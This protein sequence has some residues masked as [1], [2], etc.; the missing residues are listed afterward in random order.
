MVAKQ[1]SRHP[2]V[3]RKLREK[4]RDR[5]VVSVRPTKKGRSEI[6]ENHSIYKSKYIKNKPIRDLE[7]DEYLRLVQAQ[8]SGLI[9]LTLS[10]DGNSDTTLIEAIGRMQL[11]HRVNTFDMF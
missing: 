8:S 9:T 6:D 11:Y 3:R 10:A 7:K 4:Y 5:A 1:L 2:Y